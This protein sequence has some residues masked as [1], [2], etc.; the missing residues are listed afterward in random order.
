MLVYVNRID[1]KNLTFND[2][3]LF[4]LNRNFLNDACV[5]FGNYKKYTIIRATAGVIVQTSSAAS[6][7]GVGLATGSL[8][9]IG[10]QNGFTANI[11]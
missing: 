11:P 4:G 6:T 2:L 5:G 7:F 3:W 10:V 1:S 9:T 8:G